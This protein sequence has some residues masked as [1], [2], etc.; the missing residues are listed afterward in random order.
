MKKLILIL[1]LGLTSVLAHSQ[2]SNLPVGPLHSTPGFS[3]G[4]KTA[5][6]IISNVDQVH[7]S[8]L[9]TSVASSPAVKDYVASSTM[10][11][12]NLVDSAVTTAK[13]R[14]LNVTT[15]KLANSAVTSAKITDG[16]IVKADIASNEVYFVNPTST[17]LWT[18]ITA[19]DTFTVKYGAVVVTSSADTSILKN[20]IVRNKNLYVDYFKQNNILFNYPFVYANA[21]STY[22][23]LGRITDEGR[24]TVLINQQGGA[25]FAGSRSEIIIDNYFQ[26]STLTASNGY[27]NNSLVYARYAY[28]KDINIKVNRAQFYGWTNLFYG[29]FAMTNCRVSVQ[30][31]K[32]SQYLPYSIQ[33]GDNNKGTIFRLG[34]GTTTNTNITVNV[35]EADIMDDGI[36]IDGSLVNSRITIRVNNCKRYNVTRKALDRAL[37]YISATTDATSQIVIE[38]NYYTEQKPVVEIAANANVILRGT[39]Q[40]ASTT[41]GAIKLSASATNVKLFGCHLKTGYTASITAGTARS[42]AIGNAVT[43]NVD[44]DVNTTLVGGTLLVNSSY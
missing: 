30:A 29:S 4:K 10:G 5:P 18:G 14:N 9:K 8:N 34:G 41:E 24:G 16:T 15:G 36:V 13:L 12:G 20:I 31:D 27:N 22:L 40:T 21:N 23:N 38:G 19:L 6:I 32:I 35:N 33:A 42:I 44:K 3:M 37:I 39:Y 11:T 1:I 26:D 25:A 17:S 43:A 7:L 2:G 28:N